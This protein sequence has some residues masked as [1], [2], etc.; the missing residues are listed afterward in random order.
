[1]QSQER[2][3]NKINFFCIVGDEET[4][5]NEDIPLSKGPSLKSSAVSR[6]YRSRDKIS[7]GDSYQGDIDTY[8]RESSSKRQAPPLPSDER[9]QG[10]R[11][12]GDRRREDEG[13]H[14]S[15]S[16]EH[17][18]KRKSRKEPTNQKRER[19]SRSRSPIYPSSSSRPADRKEPRPQHNREQERRVWSTSHRP[20]HSHKAELDRERGGASKRNVHRLVEDF[21]SSSSGGDSDEGVASNETT[22]T[23]PKPVEGVE[24]N[25]SPKKTWRDVMFSDSEEEDE[26]DM[27]DI[28]KPYDEKIEVS[29]HDSDRS[30]SR[31]D[32]DEI[33]GVSLTPPIEVSAEKQDED[34]TTQPVE[35]DKVLTPTPPPRPSPSP[36]SPPTP[37]PEEILYLPALMGC[38]S[39]ECYEWLNRIEEGTYGVVFRA[40]DIR[41]SEGGREKESEGGRERGRGWR[42]EKTNLLH[43]FIK[44]S[45][46][47]SPLKTRL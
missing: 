32:D 18:T 20:A 29:P 11:R 6:S 3:L 46:L 5:L 27:K 9:K 8:K 40:R 16:L 4:F 28:T 35:D 44:F 30:A 10:E 15:R 17:K 37:P 19:R 2:P 21:E 45:L 23:P 42:G 22:P 26:D 47:F 41:T 33:K 39:V 7:Y 25:P 36:A 13:R 12:H 38:R 34:A 1:M 31:E 43:T 24:K 14:H